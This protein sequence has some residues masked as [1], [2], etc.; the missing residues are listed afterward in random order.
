MNAETYVCPTCAE[1]HDLDAIDVM[2]ED[3]GVCPECYRN[4][5]CPG[6]CNLPHLPP[7]PDRHGQWECPESGN[8]YLLHFGNWEYDRYDEGAVYLR[9]LGEWCRYD[10]ACHCDNCGNAF[11]YEDAVYPSWDE[12]GY[13]EERFC[14]RDCEQ[15]YAERNGM[16][17]GGDYEPRCEVCRDGGHELTHIH[18]VTE[19]VACGTCAAAHP[20]YVRLE[21]NLL[22]AA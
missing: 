17:G 2:H 16:T 15:E 13:S 12:D 19:T 4:P 3:H 7:E 18:P 8:V 1:E 20:E 14:S 11:H 10:E 5:D 6:D 21:D 9:S 22:V